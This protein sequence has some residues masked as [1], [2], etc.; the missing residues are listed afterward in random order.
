MEQFNQELKKKTPRKL[1]HIIQEK[2]N[3]IENEIF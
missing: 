3:G 2:Y 1:K